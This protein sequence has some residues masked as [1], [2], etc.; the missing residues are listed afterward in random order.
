MLYRKSSP[1]PPTLLLRIVATAGASALLGVSACSDVM[2]VVPDAGGVVPDAGEA[3]N[4]SPCGGGPCGSV[5]MP[6]DG[7]EA[8]VVG[9]GI[10]VSPDAGADAQGPCGGH[11]CGVLVMPPDA[12]DDGTAPSGSID[13]G[14]DVLLGVVIRPEGG[15][16]Q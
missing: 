14:R 9:G 11:V 12:G 1:K 5:V 3:G 16:D 8:G 10:V 2:G 13:S 15:F 4:P 6:P 7:G